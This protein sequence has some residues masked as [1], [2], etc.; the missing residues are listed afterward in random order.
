MLKNMSIGV[1]DWQRPELIEYYYPESLP[2]EWRFDYYLNEY[3]SAL[4]AQTEWV[5]WSDLDFDELQV[6]YRLE[7]A[8]YLRID[9]KQ[10]VPESHLAN[11]LVVLGDWVAG[12]VVFDESWSAGDKRFHGRP[13]TWVADHQAWSGWHWSFAG[14]VLSG[15]PCGWVDE[16]DS[17]PK[18]RAQML[19]SFA[20]SLVDKKLTVPFF[21]G[22][23]SIKMDDL[24]QL[25]SLAELL[26]Y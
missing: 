2:V 23:E 13:V 4:I 10:L 3:R 25:K 15:E 16:L 22:G 6:A 20:A 7:S 24:Q 12:F 14:K 8:L 1:D 26:G 9:D 11:L 17:N 18:L 19:R 21:V 5:A